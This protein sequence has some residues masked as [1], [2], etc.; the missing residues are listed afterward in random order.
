MSRW[1]ALAGLLGVATALGDGPPAPNPQE[2]VNYVRWLNE[3]YGKD[4]GV[5]AADVYLKAVD[6]LFPDEELLRQLGQTDARSWTSDQRALLRSHLDA[7]EECLKQLAAAARTDDCFFQLKSDEGQLFAVMLPELRPLR[8][9][10]KMTAARARLRL[11]EGDTEGAISDVATLL[12]FSRHMQAQ[13]STIQYLVGIAVGAL[14]Y[15][16]L[17]DVPLLASGPV[18]YEQVFRWLEGADK[19]PRRPLRAL[20]AE[21]L[22]AWDI[23]QRILHDT[24]GDGLFDTMDNIIAGRG[25]L[26]LD[27]PQ[28][29]PAVVAQITA[30]YDRVREVFVPSYKEARERCERIDREMQAKPQTLLGIFAPSM[31]RVAINQRKL[32]TERQAFRVVFHLHAYHARH[33]RWP[34]DL[35]A[36]L[37]RKSARAA[38]DPFSNRPFCYRLDDGQPLL[39]SVGENGQD[40]GGEICRKNGKVKWGPTGDYVFWP[41]QR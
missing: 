9:L 19:A 6:A 37:P 16:V 28:A 25:T 26:P 5:N 17:L 12:R 11:L 39:Y 2:P 34:A 18:K 40:D 41:R 7:H 30:H 35:K 24:D 36:A 23:A 22:T 21:E 29:F 3:E 1:F 27:P 33:G 10:S 4:I 8:T 13:H 31:T 32:I 20:E 15:D 38:I 14:A